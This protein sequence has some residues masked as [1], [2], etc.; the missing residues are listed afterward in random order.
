VSPYSWSADPDAVLAVPLLALGYWAALRVFPTRRWR[1]TCFGAALV[2]LLVAFVSPL[3]RLALHFLLTAHLLQNVV[4]AEWAPALAVLGLP[5]RLAAEAERI[6]ALR[7]LTQ[8]AVALPVWLATYFAWHVPWLYDAALR[9]PSTFLH[10]EHACYFLA[11]AAFWWPVVHGRHP[12]GR[13]AAYLFAAFVLVSPLAL[14][15]ALIPSPIYSFYEHAPRL[16]GLSPLG[17]QQ[18]A[19]V[20]MALEQAVVF[21][22]ACA[23]Y[24]GRFLREEDAQ[25]VFASPSGS[26]EPRSSPPAPASRPRP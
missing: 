16:W 18:L 10:L 15:L 1:V 12:S 9:H 6:P 14:L 17:D 26:R 24:F 20:T 21:C 19:G 25:A 2:L 23:L 11:G 4:V 13:K 5:P 8:P 22:Y 3:N 7:R